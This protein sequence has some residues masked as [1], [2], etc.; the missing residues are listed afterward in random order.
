MTETINGGAVLLALRLVRTIGVA[1]AG[2]EVTAAWAVWAYG[3][4][5]FVGA[6]LSSAGGGL[7]PL[8]FLSVARAYREG[9]SF[10]SKVETLNAVRALRMH[11]ATHA[12]GLGAS[13]G[14]SAGRV[15]D[16]WAELVTRGFEEAPC[17]WCAG[18]VG[19]D[20]ASGC[21][22]SCTPDCPARAPRAGAPVVGEG[23]EVW[24]LRYRVRV[25]PAAE[26]GPVCLALIAVAPSNGGWRALHRGARGV[27]WAPD[28]VSVLHAYA[29]RLGPEVMF[30]GV[31]S[32]AQ[33]RE[34][35]AVWADGA[36]PS[37]E[38]V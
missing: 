8:E 3:F 11:A 18:A 23:V 31:L 36:P 6:L 17:W 1:R 30:S 35:G 12:M 34:A 20:P 22:P 10:T 14:E 38:V 27:I 4:A 9:E 21:C 19:V 26:W 28:P 32:P 16:A 33:L 5:L 29:E 24:G 13:L 2:R 15:V 7:R 37:G 25:N